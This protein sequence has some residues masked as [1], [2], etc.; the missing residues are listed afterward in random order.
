L[1]TSTEKGARAA[2][3]F[4][5]RF[6]ACAAV[7]IIAPVLARSAASVSELTEKPE[8]FRIFGDKITDRIGALCANDTPDRTGAEAEGPKIRVRDQ[9]CHG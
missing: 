7:G 6:M 9:I 8:C 4:V 5:A 3:F 1:N 2:P